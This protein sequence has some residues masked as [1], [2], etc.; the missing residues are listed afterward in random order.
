MRLSPIRSGGVHCSAIGPSP[1]D[2]DI[3]YIKTHE[4]WLY[5]CNVIDLFSR[6]VVGWSA[7]SR[8]TTDL[9]IQTLL[10]ALWRR[11]P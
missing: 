10:M 1:M 4:G 9:A 3:A 5:L 6:R 8:L 2:D 11:K 7:Q